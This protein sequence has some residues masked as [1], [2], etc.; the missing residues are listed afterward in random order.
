MKNSVKYQVFVNAPRKRCMPYSKKYD[1]KE[2]AVDCMNRAISLMTC[3]SNG[4][5]LNY[6]IKEIN[7]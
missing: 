4:D 2:E 5:L 3:S 1:T 7:P 6:K